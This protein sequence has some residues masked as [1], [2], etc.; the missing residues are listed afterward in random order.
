MPDRLTLDPDRVHFTDRGVLD[1]VWPVDQ[2]WVRDLRRDLIE[3]LAKRARENDR[4]ASLLRDLLDPYG[5]EVMTALRSWRLLQEFQRRDIQVDGW[6][7]QRFFSAFHRG[8]ALGRS[9]LVE[10]LRSG[11]QR[12]RWWIP[13]WIR[14]ARWSAAIAG[15]SPRVLSPFDPGRQIAVT[16]TDDPIRLHA[17]HR[18]A[19]I[20]YVPRQDWFGPAD[21]TTEPS[22]RDAAKTILDETCSAVDGIHEAPGLFAYLQDLL[23]EAIGLLRVHRERLSSDHLPQELWTGTAGLVWNRLLQGQVRRAGGTVIGHDHAEGSGLVIGNFREVAELPHCHRFV[24]T[25]PRKARHIEEHLDP[26][27]MLNPSKPVISEIPGSRRATPLPDPGDGGEI[28]R[29]MYLSGFYAGERVSYS[30]FIPDPVKVDW[31]ARLFARLREWGYQVLNKPH[32]SSADQTHPRFDSLLGVRTLEAPFEEVW[33]WA[34][35]FIFDYAMTRPFSMALCTRKPII[36]V[37]LQRFPWVPEAREALERRCT[38]VTA[39]FDREGRVQTDWDAIR[40]TLEDPPV[41]DFEFV[42]EYIPSYV[43]EALV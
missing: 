25:T 13:G 34:D 43:P 23:E 31:Q 33:E 15:P 29:V 27:L 26:A 14:R 11:P 36:Y 5:I 4:T 6:Q 37:D 8:K 38:T 39:R 21:P 18:G 12:G 2:G 20:K 30:S 41:P 10:T 35:A 16:D 3:A 24:A 7:D 22:D 1:L 32:P 19:P 42:H 28:R 17:R 40:S 9:P